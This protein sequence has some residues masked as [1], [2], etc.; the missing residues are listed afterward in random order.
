LKTVLRP[1]VPRRLREL[2]REGR[3]GT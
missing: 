2:Y 3:R 1:H